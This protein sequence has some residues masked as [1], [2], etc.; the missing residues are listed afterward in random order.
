MNCI[1]FTNTFKLKN[2][3]K[4]THISLCIDIKLNE[5]YIAL[6]INMYI[7]F[8]VFQCLKCLEIFIHRAHYVCKTVRSINLREIFINLIINVQM[9]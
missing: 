1:F 8:S 7:T 3:H 9:L 6:R 4:C 5:I 2:V